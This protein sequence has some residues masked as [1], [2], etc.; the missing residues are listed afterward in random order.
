MMCS[1]LKCGGDVCGWVVGG[2][3]WNTVCV[4]GTRVDEKY[5]LVML[6]GVGVGGGCNWLNFDGWVGTGG[7]IM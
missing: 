5:G 3:D 1:K 4:G 6:V 2:I 7:G